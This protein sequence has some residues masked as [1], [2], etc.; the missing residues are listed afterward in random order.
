MRSAGKTMR[1]E[2][3]LTIINRGYADLVMDAA[4]NAG[5]SG[6]TIV[7]ARGT[8]I[9]EAEKF[10]GIIVQPEKEIVLILT[11]REKKNE[12]MTA[13]CTHADLKVA[14]NGICFSLPVDQVM[15]LTA[16]PDLSAS[17]PQPEPAGDGAPREAADGQGEP[18]GQAAADAP[19]E[20]GDAQAQP[21]DGGPVPT[22]DGN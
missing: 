21:S 3:I 1:H 10:F 14:G 13:I 4:K 16:P 12:I 22:S 2:L 11:E 20:S 8:G 17:A 6:G 7:H 9:H 15:G 18:A 5:A 19:A